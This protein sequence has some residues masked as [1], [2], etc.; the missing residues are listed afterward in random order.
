MNE[1]KFETSRIYCDPRPSFVLRVLPHNQQLEAKLELETKQ[2]LHGMRS[3]LRKMFLRFTHA[4][5]AQLNN[6]N[7]LTFDQWQR[8]EAKPK[9][10][11]QYK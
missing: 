11:S 5:K 10:H 6:K 9:R 2:K 4:F 8:L 7:D 3:V 1:P